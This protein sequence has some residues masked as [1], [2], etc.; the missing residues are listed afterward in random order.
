MS[1]NRLLVNPDGQVLPCCYF[2]NA[3]YL[4]DNN[5][6]PEGEWKPKDHYGIEDQLVDIGRATK[7]TAEDKVLKNYT[8]NRGEYNI[9]NKPLDEILNSEWY[10]KTLPESWDDFKKVSGFCKR[11]CTV[12]NDE[13]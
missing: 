12:K 3:L 4:C 1:T 9:F 2:A 5:D 7:N 6:V 10:T 8:E 11:Y 13:L